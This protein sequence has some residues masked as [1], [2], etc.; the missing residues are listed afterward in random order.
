MTLIVYGDFTSPECY[1]ASR[2]VSALRMVGVD[3]E[4]H[5]VEREPQLPVSGR[6]MTD[7]QHRDLTRRFSQLNDELLTGETLPWV[8]PA[9]A[10]K[11]E[12]AVSAYAEAYGAGVG[13]D[14]RRL[15]FEL[16]WLHGADIGN[17]TVLRT[18][19][20]GPVLRGHS[21]VDS[22]HRFGF[23]V[24]VDRG[25]ITTDAFRRIGSWRKEWQDLRRSDMPCVQVQDQT[26]TGLDAVRRLGEEVSRL[27]PNPE[28]LELPDPSRYPP[29]SVH[30]DPT[31]VSQVGGTWEDA[32]HQ[33]PL[34]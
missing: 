5:A 22:L 3:V 10:V 15:L 16:Y 28:L 20:V 24:S 4:W 32:Y 19:L 9:L 30:P 11:T 25:P 23:A 2:R 12:A 13:E 14:V 21:N 27:Q 26:F 18:P 17:P 29:L 34:D 31:W 6:A 33:S 1:I 7:E 8:A